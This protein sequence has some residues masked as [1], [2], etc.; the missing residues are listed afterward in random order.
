[1]LK[2]KALFACLQAH[3]EDNDGNAFEEI[4]GVCVPD[5]SVAWAR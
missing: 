5:G 3:C 2:N 4:R 1:V